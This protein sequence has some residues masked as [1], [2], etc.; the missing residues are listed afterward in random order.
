MSYFSHNP[1]AYDE[2][3]VKG[4]TDKLLLNAAEDATEE[5][6]EFLENIISNFLLRIVLS[7]YKQ[8]LFCSSFIRSSIWNIETRVKPLQTFLFGL[9][10]LDVFPFEVLI[11]KQNKEPQH[12]CHD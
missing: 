3:M 11:T 7:T 2:I 8:K 12:P 5:Q 10:C 6:R 4:V 1:E 9:E